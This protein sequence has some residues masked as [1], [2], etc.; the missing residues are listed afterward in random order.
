MKKF[1]LSIMFLIVFVIS[2]GQTNKESKE[3]NV[4]TW[5]Y[6]IPD[7]V[8][9][10]FEKETGIKV[11]MSYYDSNDTMMAK[12]M[13]G[14]SQYDIITPSTDFVDVMIKADLLTKLDKSKLGSTFDNLDYDRFNLKEISKKYDDDFNYSIPY[15]YFATGITVNTE[16]VGKDFDKTIDIFNNEKYAGKMTMLDDGRETLGMVLQSLGYS[17]ATENDD[18]LNEAKEILIKI[19]KNLAKFDNNTFGKGLASGEFYISHGYPDL[20]YEV[21]GEELDKY[22][23]FLPKGAMMYIDSMAITKKSENLDNA[24]KFLEYL[25]RPENYTKVFELFRMPSV[26][27]NVEENTEIK[28]IATVEEIVENSVLPFSLSDTAKEK[29]DKIW[30]EVKLAH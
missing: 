10:G 14:S 18:E 6:F 28:P 15:G 20:F 23:Y 8:I 3:V 1:L 16:V 30:N 27:K 2:C 11:N 5:T 4:Y 19:K 21:E 25:Y 9:E 17:S 7:E 29:Q 26:I 12:L 24:Y 22:V 13:T